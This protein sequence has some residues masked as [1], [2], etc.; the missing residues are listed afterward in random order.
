MPSSEILEITDD[1][2][3]T[4][5]SINEKT[6][7]LRLSTDVGPHMRIMSRA[8]FS[9]HFATSENMFLDKL[10]T[11]NTASVGVNLPEPKT[12][13]SASQLV[14]S[15]DQL[16]LRQ[17]REEHTGGRHITPLALS[18]FKGMSEAAEDALGRPLILQSAYRSPGYQGL[19]FTE[20]LAE[21]GFDLDATIHQVGIPG[22]SEHADADRLAID[23]M[24]YDVVTPSFKFEDLPEYDW[25]KEHAAEFDFYESY[26]DGN[27]AGLIFEPW[28]WQHH[29]N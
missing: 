28:H 9:P 3:R 26:P 1:T 23:I 14:L 25:L 22:H 4:V 7:L 17:D 12:D 6:R 27:E 16:F 13:V 10:P 11:I 15:P 24:P 21:T 2:I 18:A 5:M 20:I 8:A 19:L 29:P